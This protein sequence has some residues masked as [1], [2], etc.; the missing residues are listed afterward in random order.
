MKRRM[1]RYVAHMTD[2]EYAAYFA[3]SGAMPHLKHTEKSLDGSLRSVAR[4]LER[5][6]LEVSS[7]T[8]EDIESI[9]NAV[10]IGL[11]FNVSSPQQVMDLLTDADECLR[12]LDACDDPRC[13]ES[14]CLHVRS[15]ISA[16]M[17][18]TNRRG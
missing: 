16:I 7:M 1:T 9:A 14:N 10:L 12:D 3:E 11:G 8:K 18:D 5:A 4:S 6:G 15:R 13:K 17:S 2:D